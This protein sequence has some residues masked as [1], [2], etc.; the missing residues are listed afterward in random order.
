MDE[1]PVTLLSTLSTLR[2]H[3]VSSFPR[4][5]PPAAPHPLSSVAP[6]EFA[7][8]R[9][10]LGSTVSTIRTSLDH[11]ERLLPAPAADAPTPAATAELHKYLSLLTQ[12]A[13]TESVLLSI[14]HSSSSTAALL[15]SRSSQYPT[16]HPHER[17]AP[18]ILPTL[19][20]IARDLGLV[21]FRDDEGQAEPQQTVT[22]SLGG[23][24]M[25]VDVEVHRSESTAGHAEHVEKVKVAYVW[26]GEQL[27]D[28]KSARKLSGLFRDSAPRSQDG[29]VKED[30]WNDVRGILSE[31]HRLDDRTAKEDLDY[32]ALVARLDDS[33]R[34][35]FPVF[36]ASPGSLFPRLLL[37][38]SPSSRL[39]PAYSNTVH[40]G[41][42]MR[43]FLDTPGIYSG[44]FELP[45]AASKDASLVNDAKVAK[46]WFR[47]RLEPEVPTPKRVCERILA[48]LDLEIGPAQLRTAGNDHDTSTTDSKLGNDEK[49]RHAVPDRGGEPM[50]SE[51]NRYAQ[52]STWGGLLTSQALDRP[53]RGQMTTPRALTTSASAQPFRFELSVQPGSSSAADPAAICITCLW[54]VERPG[55]VELT[56]ERLKRGIRV[57]KH[58]IEF[59]EL[60]S[61]VQPW[62]VPTVPSRFQR[63]DAERPTKRRRDSSSGPQTLDELFDRDQR[64]TALPV[65][66]H[67]SLADEDPHSATIGLSFPSPLGPSGTTGPMT[68]RITRDPSSGA[69]VVRS[70][71]KSSDEASRRLEQAESQC[72]KVVGLTQDLAILMRFVVDRLKS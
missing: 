37:H 35:A 21:C 49:P 20:R 13:A 17:T 24:V 58:Q 33:V 53:S 50:P 64:A 11:F 51:A 18:L 29:Q 23:Q 36:A 52:K 8:V 12:S 31:L 66:I 32:F 70:R 46:Q 9:A 30:L 55:D 57:L 62:P 14:A 15:E 3:L 68:I 72:A 28:D 26:K 10:R 47:F 5:A 4:A 43:A 1:P 41:S 42:A 71:S 65:G 56:M 27:F 34:Q 16:L 54:A 45:A 6:S 67:L 48:A 25:V 39:Y 44:V 60:V 38:S 7:A 40:A 22:L 2:S 63:C 61:S 69:L 19:E 59:N